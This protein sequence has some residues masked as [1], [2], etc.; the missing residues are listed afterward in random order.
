MK[1]AVFIALNEM[2]VEQHGLGA[3][4]SIVDEADTDGVY[5]STSN[6]DDAEMF[7]LVEVIC[8]TLN[9]P[10][11]AVLKEFGIY[12]FDFLHKAHPVFAEAQPDFFSF[13]ESIDGVIHVEVHKLDENAQTP[14]ID[15]TKCSETQ[16]HLRYKSP[17]K[18]CHLAE[19][20]LIGAASLY[21]IEIT[22]SQTACMHSGSESCTLVI[23]RVI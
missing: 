6:Y 8:K 23:D 12:L 1:G 2:V 17:R 11:D 18:L 3:W 14:E 15:V 21:G 20:L 22:V 13:I 16:A 5:T 4:L 19:G 7:S 9:A 10:A